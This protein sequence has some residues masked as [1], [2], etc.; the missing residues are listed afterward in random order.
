MVI[1]LAL[2]S[3]GIKMEPFGEE[4]KSVRRSIASTDEEEEAIDPLDDNEQVE[5]DMHA[6]HLDASVETEDED[7][8]THWISFKTLYGYI[9]P[10]FLMCIAYLDPGNLEAD[11]QVGAYTGYS[12]LWLLA[13]ATTMGWLLQHL[14]LKLGVVTGK[15]LATVCREQYPRKTSLVIWFFAELAI[16]GSD[17]Q[18][19]TG[20][21]IALNILTGIP[22]WAG[23]LVT[24][25]DTLTFLGL[26]KYGVRKLEVFF[27]FLIAIMTFSFFANFWKEPPKA[28]DLLRGFLPSVKSYAMRP[29][30]GL[31]G[32]VIMP[33]NIYLHSALVLSRRIDR[34]NQRKVREANKYFTIEAALSLFVSFCI[35]VTV[36]GCFAYH[37]FAIECATAPVMS[38][39]MVGSS[40]W[41]LEQVHGT[42]AGGEGD[43][44]EIGL[45]RAGQALTGA[46][47]KSAKYIWAIGLL[48][49]GQASTM[50]GTYAGQY[51]MEGFLLLKIDAW[52]RVLITRTIALVPAVLWLNILQSLVLPFALLPVLHFTSDENLM[53]PFKN[54][55]RLR[56]VVWLMALS[57]IFVNIMLI[58]F[59]V[60]DPNSPLPATTPFYILVAVMALG[61][62]AF[63]FN[64]V[65]PDLAAFCS[66]LRQSSQGGLTRVAPISPSESVATPVDSPKS[67][68]FLKHAGPVSPN[69]AG[70]PAGYQDQ[71]SRNDASNQM[72]LASEQFDSSE[73]VELGERSP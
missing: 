54:Q 18:E 55:L 38:A 42:C 23:C 14:A 21:A 22:M 29:A 67:V 61:Y 27:A 6:E 72:L 48:A 5:E 53:G 52:K 13:L 59:F 47:G 31:I 62:F 3:I 10:G 43:C 17:I 25:L 35:N 34:N 7:P 19:V 44:Q 71:N 9:G 33:H 11:L 50:T 15:H 49:A 2:S 63:I 30:V 46:L 39:C 12:L 69:G 65:R 26:H 16:I 28:S 45:A 32:A 64:M 8:T 57:I 37:F 1:N 51:V 56:I 60:S 40:K 20:S 4:E 70:G 41:A 58:F 68:P 36:V 66:C 73:P 24:G